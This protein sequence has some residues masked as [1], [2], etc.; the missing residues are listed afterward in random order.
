MGHAAARVARVL[1]KIDVLTLFPGMFAGPMS[2][3]MIK[4]AQEGG[5]LHLGIH[6]L[7]AHADDKHHTADD[8]PFGGG[9][10]MV[11]KPDL[12][13]EAVEALGPGQGTRILLTCPQGRRFD[14]GIAEDLS[15]A[16]HLIFLCGHYEGFDER[17][18]E[19]L[20]TDELSIGD[21]VLTNGELPAMVMIDALV[22]LIPGVVGK[23]A[24][25]L[26]DSFTTGLLDYPHYT[27]PVSFR[28]WEVPEILRSGHHAAIRRW[29]REQALSR[30]YQ[31]R[32]DLLP[33]APLDSR[34]LTFLREQCGWMPAPPS[35]QG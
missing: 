11:I 32:P 6:D 1:V 33:V 24:S 7:R 25:T 30:T 26:E 31:R 15:R 18:R 34:D 12:V 27:R 5:Y 4:R 21:Y 35:S 2:E 17:V 10:G 9:A 29:R 13:F 28:G 22:R 16:E 14:Q 20:V 3:S 19:H 23:E 8:R